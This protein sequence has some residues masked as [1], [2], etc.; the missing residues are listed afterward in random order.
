MMSR[1]SP[2]RRLAAGGT[3]HVMAT[4][5]N[6]CE[7]ALGKA[8]GAQ[9][10][11]HMKPSGEHTR[12]AQR[13]HRVA[14]FSLRPNQHGAALVIGLI[15]LALLSILG[16]AATS[17]GV[18][19]QRMAANARDRIRAFE[20]AEAGL[21]ACEAR[22][23]LF[24]HVTVIPEQSAADLGVHIPLLTEGPRCTI[25]RVQTVMGGNQSLETAAHET[26]SYQVYRLTVEARGIN[27]NTVV[28]LQAH[29]R[30]RI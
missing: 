13:S 6:R 21:L 26:D 25:T 18:M 14:R 4:P 10:A 7:Q 1:L 24:R 19:E 3:R 22:L 12:I 2:S 29:V 11:R 8:P 17:T 15:M 9:R 5:K 30:L 20:A 23:P 28:R 16:L 27:P